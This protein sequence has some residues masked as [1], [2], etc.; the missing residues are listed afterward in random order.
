MLVRY[1]CLVVCGVRCGACAIRYI[2]VCVCAWAKCP[3]NERKDE[4]FLICIIEN[5]A[6]PFIDHYL[7]VDV[8]LIAV[9]VAVAAAV[10]VAEYLDDSIMET[11][12]CYHERPLPSQ[13]VD[14]SSVFP[15]YLK[16]AD[17]RAVNSSRI[18]CC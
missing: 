3:S 13:S 11:V 18:Y 14:S 12:K 16:L 10:S 4:I 2:Y 6:R 9:A 8:N 15:G 7:R 5:R 1:C 17:C